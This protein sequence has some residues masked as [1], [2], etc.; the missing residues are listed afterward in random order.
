MLVFIGEIEL[1][2]F[3]FIFSVAVFLA[4]WQY[5]IVLPRPKRIFEDNSSTS[6]NDLETQLRPV[7]VC[8]SAVMHL[9]VGVVLFG[10][11][12]WI[13]GMSTRAILFG[14]AFFVVSF[15]QTFFRISSAQS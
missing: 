4:Y 7:A 12:W 2:A 10:M 5:K 14:F 3:P 9:S 13:T 8:C 1:V 6:I 11:S 15:S